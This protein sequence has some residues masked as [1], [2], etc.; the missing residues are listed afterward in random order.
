MKHGAGA[1]V[2]GLPEGFRMLHR[3]YGCPSKEVMKI[4]FV[5]AAPRYG[6]SE[7]GSIGLFEVSGGK[8]LMANLTLTITKT[9]RPG[10]ALKTP[11]A[12]STLRG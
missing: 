5:K 1:D 7:S 3:R 4:P 6:V 9:P 10:F 2:E 8:P 12:L 11:R